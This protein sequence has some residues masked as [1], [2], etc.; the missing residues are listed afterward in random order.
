MK[1]MSIYG[2]VLLTALGFS[3][4]GQN[5]C[6]PDEDGD[7][8][9]VDEGDCDDTNAAVFPGADEVC[10]GI[11]ND[12]DGSIDEAVRTIYYEDWDGDGYGDPN[13]STKECEVPIGYVE[14]ADDCDD[15]DA[16]VNPAATEICDGLDND[17]DGMVDENTCQ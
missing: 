4:M 2:A 7:G 6:S 14:N 15:L 5:G 8:W 11:D 1:T 9:E 13:V 16:S 17:C 3:A 10:D 12:C